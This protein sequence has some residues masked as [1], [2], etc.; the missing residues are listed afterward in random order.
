MPP[1]PFT[2][3]CCRHLSRCIW[4][5][6]NRTHICPETGAH[7]NT[8]RQTQ[9]LLLA[10]CRAPGRNRTFV[11]RLTAARSAIEPPE[12]IVSK[13]GFAPSATLLRRQMLCTELFVQR[14]D[15]CR[16]LY[17]RC[18]L[19]G[20]VLHRISPISTWPSEAG[21]GLQLPSGCFGK[22]ILSSAGSIFENKAHFSSFD[23]QSNA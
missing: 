18:C 21:K 19:S 2:H 11:R 1:R 6:G 13:E 8:G 22:P 15:C 23:Y 20:S 3:E 14:T 9:R 10:S 7:T 5:G 17:T 16:C 12:H 4:F